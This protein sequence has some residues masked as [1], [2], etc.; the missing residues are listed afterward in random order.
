MP[1]IVLHEG[2]DEELKAAAVFYESRRAGLGESFLERV[3]EGFEL[4]RTQPLAGQVTF[5]N[6]RRVLIQ[7]FPYS[8]IY[9][10]EADT[11]FVVAIA[12]WR[13]RPMYWKPRT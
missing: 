4:I 3:S 13:R 2:A 12:H 1:E 6:Y 10:V 7:Q 5:K 11:V 9:R 8:I